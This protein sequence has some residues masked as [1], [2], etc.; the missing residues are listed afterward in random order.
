MF[1][2]IPIFKFNRVAV[3]K[4]ENPVRAVCRLAVQ[5]MSE[6]APSGAELRHVVP[7]PATYA[8]L[9]SHLR[10]RPRT[11]DTTRRVGSHPPR[12]FVLLQGLHFLIFVVFHFVRFLLFVLMRRLWCSFYHRP[13]HVFFSYDSSVVL[14]MKMLA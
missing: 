1:Q 11:G 10:T 13:C 12:V 5:R 9:K 2:L 6:T 4:F 8:L 14:N 7:W 3:S